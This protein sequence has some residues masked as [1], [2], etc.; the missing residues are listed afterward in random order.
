[1]AESAAHLERVPGR[2]LVVGLFCDC[3][4]TFLLNVHNHILNSD[5]LIKIE[6]LVD[7][8]LG[9]ALIVPGK[10]SLSMMG[11]FNLEALDAKRFNY[12]KP[13]EPP[14]E[15]KATSTT[16]L[17]ITG[18]ECSTNLPNSPNRPHTL[19]LPISNRN[20]HRPFLYPPPPWAL[21]LSQHHAHT[22]LDPMTSYPKHLSDHA[23]LKITTSIRPKPKT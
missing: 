6:Q 20:D 12:R 7:T 1:M 2:A 15:T 8:I 16:L 9:K 4:Q 10:V 19:P 13:S 11:D 21:A 3:F 17:A 14:P 22:T 18:T 23:S 5:D